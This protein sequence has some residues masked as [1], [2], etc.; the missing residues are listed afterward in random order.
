MLMS[1]TLIIGL[2][3]YLANVD[4]RYKGFFCQIADKI[5]NIKNVLIWF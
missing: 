2:V 5:N 4:Y 3:D 1:Y